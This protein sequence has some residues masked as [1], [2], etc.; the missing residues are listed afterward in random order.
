M[1]LPAVSSAL[2]GDSFGWSGFPR[3]YLKRKNIMI[4]AILRPSCMSF[5]NC[6]ELVLLFPLYN[7]LRLLFAWV[8]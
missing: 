5:D 7:V 3:H 4:E 6:G 2:I 8:S 1:S